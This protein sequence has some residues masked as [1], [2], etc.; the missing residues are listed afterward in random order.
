[1]RRK[2]KLFRKADLGLQV[3]SYSVFNQMLVQLEKSQTNFPSLL[4]PTSMQTSCAQSINQIYRLI[5]PIF[6]NNQWINKFF[7][8]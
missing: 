1:L 6:K 8:D 3:L 2:V 5:S 4:F 7:P